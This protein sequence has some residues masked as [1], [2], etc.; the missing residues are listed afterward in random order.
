MNIPIINN[1][2]I[3]DESYWNKLKAD[4]SK[5]DI[6]CEINNTICRTYLD[7]GKNVTKN[8]TDIINERI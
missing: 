2:I 4:Y 5:T 3:I 8:I 1:E 6:I 7:L